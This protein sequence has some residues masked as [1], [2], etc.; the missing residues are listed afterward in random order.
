MKFQFALALKKEK[1]QQ[2]VR[3]REKRKINATDAN[4]IV[5]T[6][7]ENCNAQSSAQTTLT[8]EQKA[9]LPPLYQIFNGDLD[10]I[11][12]HLEVP[13]E[14]LP[15][16]ENVQPYVSFDII[17][18]QPKH[19]KSTNNY[20]SMA[21][22]N[23]NWV[24]RIEESTLKPLFYPC[25]H[26]EPCS[27]ATCPCVQKGQ[28]CTKHC[29]YSSG[30][31]NFF[32]GCA[33]KAGQCRTNACSCYAAGRECDPDLCKNCQ[34]PTCSSCKNNSITLRK[35]THLLLAPST[36]AGWGVYN[37]YSLK[38]GDFIQE[39]VGE[40]M[41]QHEAERRGRIY[42]KI[43]MSY[44]FNLCTDHV[45]DANWK[46]NKTR[47]INH[48]DIPNVECKVVMVNGDYRIGMYAKKDIKPQTELFFDYKY[49]TTIE[50][51]DFCK[52]K[53]I[54]EWMT[55]PSMAGKVSIKNV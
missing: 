55:N 38:K 50:H 9:L 5:P 18:P 33:C 37:R 35:H 46:G 26:T 16:P 54:V 30:S 11:S 7:L 25:T 51:S 29:V 34:D 22:Y 15:S 20:T 27:E 31:R 32:R 10:I 8:S 14:L 47:F 36:V 19:K 52:P 49:D 48:S 6:P 44:L 43:N 12:N 24:K 3:I 23:Q 2:C 41:S 13:K 1:D 45:I 42:D 4:N 40:A 28:W 21:N 17:P 39:Y 53:T